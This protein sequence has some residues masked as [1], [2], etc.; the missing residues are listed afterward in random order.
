MPESL[1]WVLWMSARSG[2]FEDGVSSGR[3][4]GG[5]GDWSRHMAGP[6]AR[7]A[8]RWRLGWTLCALLDVARI[9]DIVAS[10][11]GS[12]RGWLWCAGR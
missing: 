7:C 8:M 9:V 3:W 11:Q 5:A 4:S 10:R 1:D 12:T 2:W 6:S